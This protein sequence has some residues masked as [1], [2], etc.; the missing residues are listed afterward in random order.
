[1]SMI[2]NEGIYRCR[3]QLDP[4]TNAPCIDAIE[5]FAWD[6]E[7][8]CLDEN[9]P[10]GGMQLVL[11]ADCYR[12]NDDGTLSPNREELILD[13]FGITFITKKEQGEKVRQELVANLVRIFGL[14]DA[15]ELMTINSVDASILTDAT[16]DVRLY[17]TE[18]KNGK[19]YP[20]Y[21]LAPVGEAN[22]S[23]SSFVK[24]VKNKATVNKYLAKLRV[25]CKDIVGTPRPAPTQAVKE[26]P[27]MPKKTAP[28]PTPS[29]PLPPREEAPALDL[30]AVWAMWVNVRPEDATTGE[31]FYAAIGEMFG[32][33]SAQDLTFN[34][35]SAF[36]KR[37]DLKNSNADDDY[38]DIPF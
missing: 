26:A 16:F 8:K 25:E 37:W 18:G 10:L 4:S 2:K 38:S 5:H 31:K 7:N 9:C 35:L 1:M 23:K 13:N 30:D 20:N 32:D 6:K 29:K 33:K 3:L 17:Y 27:T 28:M 24:P 11:R 12:V 22:G 34:E 36:V 21:W 15:G 19:S 14:R